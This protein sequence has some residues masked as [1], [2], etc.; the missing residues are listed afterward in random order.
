[1][2]KQCIIL[3][4]APGS[5][6][7]T[8]AK[9]LCELLNIPQISTGD[10]FRDNIKRDTDIGKIAKGYMDRGALVPD[11]VTIS[12]LAERLKLNDVENG[13]ILDGF[14]RSIVQAEKLDKL[15]EGIGDKISSVVYI[16]VAEEEILERLSGRR[17]CTKCQSPY[18]T[19]FMP[20][21]VDGICD[22][23]GS[24][25]SIRDDDKPETIK[26]RFAIFKE[27]TMPLVKFYNERGLL[28]HLESTELDRD[29]EF[30]RRELKI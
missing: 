11:E 3:L 26:K 17:I 22:K 28:I 7:G 12:L 2:G 16:D 4:G 29:I 9:V 23:C 10:L 30:L 1:M 18:H 21:K 15:L 14:P 6:K 20:P 19:T 5:G 24:V 25:L 8:R 13:F 27:T